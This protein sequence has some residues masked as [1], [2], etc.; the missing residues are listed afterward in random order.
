[1]IHHQKPLRCDRKGIRY[2]PCGPHQKVWKDRLMLITANAQ[3]DSLWCWYRRL[4]LE[5]DHLLEDCI[6]IRKIHPLLLVNPL[7]V[8]RVPIAHTPT[9]KCSSINNNGITWH[10]DGEGKHRAGLLNLKFCIESSING[11]KF[12]RKSRF[13]TWEDM[14]NEN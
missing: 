9:S 7:V 13:N 5:G 11:I 12:S 6:A 10:N 4:S 1:M 14:L 3:H 8:V 2:T